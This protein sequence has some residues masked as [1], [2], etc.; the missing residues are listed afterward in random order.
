[1]LSA[2]I[3]TVH[4][5]FWLLGFVCTSKINFVSLAVVSSFYLLA[6]F[7]PESVCEGS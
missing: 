1:M 7:D 2:W 4:V 6:K 5:Y 3:V